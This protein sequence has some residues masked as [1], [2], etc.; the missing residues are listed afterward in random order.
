MSSRLTARNLKALPTAGGRRREDDDLRSVL[1]TQSTIADFVHSR[2]GIERLIERQI[3]IREVSRC[4]KYGYKYTSDAKNGTSLLSFEDVTIVIASTK[5]DEL[6][7]LEE[8]NIDKRV[9]LR[10]EADSSTKVLVTAY[11]E[12]I[13]DSFTRVQISPK[14]YETA[15]RLNRMATIDGF[16]VTKLLG[17]IER[18]PD[19]EES[20]NILNFLNSRIQF[21]LLHYAAYHCNEDVIRALVRKGANP[22]IPALASKKCPPLHYILSVHNAP[23]EETRLLALRALWESST[24]IDVNHTAAGVTALHKALYNKLPNAA[25]FLINQGANMDAVNNYGE[26]ARSMAAVF[27]ELVLKI[28]G[29]TSGANAEAAT[30]VIAIIQPDTL[31]ETESTLV[32][33]DASDTATT[34]S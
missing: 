32:I 26:S 21:T 4:I 8:E 17:E 14:S 10:V 33:A 7:V 13:E 20:A 24:S 31:S 34:S 3:S 16:Q 2:H 27:P 30:Q 25:E 29:I 22:N 28:G 1:T 18:L 12:K 11:R 23:T 19:S 5:V 15:K 9:A 6:Q